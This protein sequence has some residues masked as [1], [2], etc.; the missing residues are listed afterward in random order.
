[1]LVAARDVQCE[2]FERH[3]RDIVNRYGMTVRH[4]ID[5][6]GERMWLAEYQGHA[7]CISWDDWFYEVTVM[8]WDDT[9]DDVIAELYARF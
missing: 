3:A 5:G 8:T 9:P 6:H 2:S 7:L 1:M 4:K